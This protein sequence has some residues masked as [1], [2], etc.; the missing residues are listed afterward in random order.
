[1]TMMLG[2]RYGQRPP[3]H[4]GKRFRF[5]RQRCIEFDRMSS[6]DVMSARSTQGA[7]DYEVEITSIDQG[8]QRFSPCYGVAF[9]FVSPAD[10]VGMRGSVTV[11]SDPYGGLVGVDVAL[12]KETERV[13]ERR[14]KEQLAG[15]EAK[16]RAA[17]GRAREEELVRQME[18]AKEATKTSRQQ[19]DYDFA[20]MMAVKCDDREILKGLVKE[21]QLGAKQAPIPAP[22]PAKPAAKPTSTVAKRKLLLLL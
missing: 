19:A 13:M 17:R 16:E 14:D 8:L 22:M 10:M 15:A 21:M 2:D 4:P 5:V 12:R 18:K 6:L 20:M 1:M 3:V 11:E 9:K 7:E